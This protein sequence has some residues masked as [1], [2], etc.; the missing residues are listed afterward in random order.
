[1]QLEHL[2]V[3]DEVLPSWWA[4]ALQAYLSLGAWGF[5]VTKQDATHIEVVAAANDQA[6]VIAIEGSWRWI[7]ATVNRAHPGGA[8]ATFDVFVTGIA[9][10]I[11][12]VPAAY[13]DDTNYA[14]A[15]AIVAEGDTPTI[16][17]GVVDI[18]RRV[19]QL[20]WDGAQIIW[21]DQLVPPV[22]L[23][24]PTHA[25]GGTDPITPAAIGAAASADLTTEATA[26]V[27]ADAAEV[28]ARAAADI[29][30][31]AARATADGSEATTRAAADTAEAATRATADG[32]E[33]TARAAGDNLRTV[34]VA[35]MGSDTS[36]PQVAGTVVGH[37]PVSKLGS[38]SWS[39]VGV[40]TRAIVA[41]SG[42]A[43][44]YKVQTDN[45]SGTGVLAD[46]TG[47]DA[48]HPVVPAT[49]RATRTGVTGGPMPLADLD[50][51]AV[52]LVVAGT[53][54]G[55]SIALEF[56]RTAP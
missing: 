23:H 14:F 8:A 48:A 2:F 13:T 28:I 40:I 32:A 42:T 39:L 56:A 12:S 30:E 37:V 49:G 3:R 21:I 38:D 50:T 55:I 35:T 25:T 11:V 47:I 20:G 10:D 43:S 44:S 9:T 31:A 16:V 54:K 1:M 18:Y 51:V 15:L 41:P 26:R 46:V 53:T 34:H 7:E 6:A 19:A 45:G 24:A 17:A 33:A 29:A 27:A 36:P 4:N 52:V 5:Q 22:P